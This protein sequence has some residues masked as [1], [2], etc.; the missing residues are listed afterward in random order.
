M[1]PQDFDFELPDSLIAQA[2][3]A[4]RTDSRLL[5]LRRADGAL[6]TRRFRDLVD[7]LGPKDLL[8]LNE[9]RVLRARLRGTR[10]S[11][12]GSVEFLAIRP[13]SDT[14]WLA[15]AKP[16]KRLR[17]GD[18]AHIPHPHQPRAPMELEIVEKREYG[19]VTI[20][21]ADGSPLGP[22]LADYGEIPLP[23]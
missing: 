1:R 7:T 9:S 10:N 14:S 13:H 11:S 5:G 15:L 23:P 20:R 19:L 4:E 17:P 12:G 3:A 16:A 6:S 2:P 8:V 22:A 21:R 18:R